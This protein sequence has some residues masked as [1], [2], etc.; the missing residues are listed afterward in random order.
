MSQTHFTLGAFGP[1]ESN[2]T[3][4][5]TKI[6]V[7][8]I[9]ITVQDI[10]NGKASTTLTLWDGLREIGKKLCFINTTK[11]YNKPQTYS[12]RLLTKWGKRSSPEWQTMA[13]NRNHSKP[14]LRPVSIEKLPNSDKY[15]TLNF[16][17]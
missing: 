1:L 16:I 10:G 6:T 5:T 17:I 15:K 8:L 9:K 4:P 11:W 2:A 13:F 14:G 3:Y 7:Q 12:R